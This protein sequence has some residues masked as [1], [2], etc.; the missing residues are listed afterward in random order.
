MN[1]ILLTTA[2]NTSGGTRQALYLARG[3]MSAGHRLRFFTPPASALRPLDPSIPWRD[4]PK[5]FFAAG[6]ALEAEIRAMA[7]NPEHP[8]PVALHV[9]HNR[10]IKL[11]A[12]WGLIWFLRRLPVACCMHRGVIYRPRN[13]LPYLLPGIKAYI[14]NSRAC[15][16]T[17]PLL[18]RKKRC[19]LVYNSI[20]PER[21]QT[22]LTREETLQALNLAE[23]RTATEFARPIIGC[24]ANDKP[25][26]GVETLLRA[27]ALGGFAHKYGADL[28]IVGVTEES[29]APLCRSLGISSHVRLVP[30]TENV[31]NYLQT[32]SLFVIPSFSESQP[33]TLLEA[34]SLGIPALGSD[35]GGIPEALSE[36]GPTDGLLFRP[37]DIEEA[38]EKIEALLGNPARLAGLAAQNR[39]ASALFSQEFRLQRISK[40]YNEILQEVMAR[41][42]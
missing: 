26:K 37:G 34:M 28:V 20:P 31:A 33:N 1:I 27:F 18:W 16:A 8:G 11:A 40:I 14:V 23:G 42:I 17:L 9:F 35:V 5:G 25:N 19:H 21:L 30:P 24:V 6:K 41:N 7:E 10:G 36:A 38:A 4:L 39:A 15:A 12:F 22:T 29:F 3:L 2:G 13:P 32:F